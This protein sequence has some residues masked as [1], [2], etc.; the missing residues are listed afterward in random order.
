MKRRNEGNQ[1]ERKWDIEKWT[2]ITLFQGENSVF[3]NRQT[4]KQK[5]KKGLGPICVLILVRESAQKKSVRSTETV[6][7]KKGGPQINVRRSYFANAV[8]S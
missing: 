6:V 4:K 7:S 5:E 2:K 3:V 1:G 8:S